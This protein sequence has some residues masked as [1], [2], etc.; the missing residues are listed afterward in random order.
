MGFS[1]VLFNL[2]KI[3]WQSKEKGFGSE[4]KNNFLRMGLGCRVRFKLLA[5]G[6]VM[7][8]DDE[9]LKNTLEPRNNPKIKIM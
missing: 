8:E 5:T 2:F 6:M 7:T 4:E 3:I 9:S 1:T